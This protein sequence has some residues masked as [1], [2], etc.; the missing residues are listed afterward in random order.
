[1]RKPL[2]SVFLASNVV[3]RHA[4]GVLRDLAGVT[5]DEYGRQNRPDPRSLSLRLEGLEIGGK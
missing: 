1:M 5:V 4:P 3:N 2:S